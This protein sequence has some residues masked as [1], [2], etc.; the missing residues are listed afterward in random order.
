[1]ASVFKSIDLMYLWAVAFGHICFAQR[2][3]EPK[4]RCPYGTCGEKCYW[5]VES[6][7]YYSVIPEMHN[8]CKYHEN[9]VIF[10]AYLD[11]R[12]WLLAGK[13]P[14]S[15][16]SQ[17]VRLQIIQW[18]RTKYRRTAGLSR[19]PSKRMEGK[20]VRLHFSPSPFVL[21]YGCLDQTFETETEKLCLVP[22]RR[23]SNAAP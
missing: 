19:N 11:Q 23:R 4:T 1:M 8:E 10:E 12:N 15:G 22:S 6:L 20:I 5:L 21:P 17:R 14:R 18:D 16:R 2:D 7:P 3:G 13:L 9:L